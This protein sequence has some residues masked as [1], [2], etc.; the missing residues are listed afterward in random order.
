MVDE[1]GGPDVALDTTFTRGAPQ[2]PRTLMVSEGA[3]R[4][5]TGDPAK[6]THVRVWLRQLQALGYVR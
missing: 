4:E 1:D 6:A 2:W 5:A 3:W